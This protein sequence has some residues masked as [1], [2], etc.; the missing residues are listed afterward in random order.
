MRRACERGSVMVITLLVLAALTVLGISTIYLTGFDGEIALNM[1]AGDQALY[2]AEAGVNWGISKGEADDSLILN[3][4][5]TSGYGGGNTDVRLNDGTSDLT[6]AGGQAATVAVKIQASR[7]TNGSSV[8][9][10]IP[11]FS[12]RFGSY[13]FRVDSKGNGPSGAIREV[14]AHIL[15]PPRDG[16][17]P[18]GKRVTGGY[19]GG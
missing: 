13:R 3:G 17:C 15:L 18:A 8:H 10:G 16:L 14:E 7:D 11:G 12:D 5:S 9:C 19:V 1:R 2:I 6:F 4:Y